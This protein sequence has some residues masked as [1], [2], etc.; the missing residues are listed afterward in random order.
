MA[1]REVALIRDGLDGVLPKI[2]GTDCPQF[3]SPEEFSSY[4]LGIPSEELLE[5]GFQMEDER[6]VN[7]YVPIE[8]LLDVRKLVEIGGA[9]GKKYGRKHHDNK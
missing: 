1:G 6:S 9:L 2:C 8:F 3:A 7:A 5:L 4:S